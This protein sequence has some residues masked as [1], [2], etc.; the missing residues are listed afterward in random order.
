MT[1]FKNWE[2]FVT[3]KSE[4]IPGP[5]DNSPIAT[6]HP[7]T[8]H[9]IFKVGSDSASISLEMWQ[10]LHG[11]YGGGPAVSQSN[12]RTTSYSEK[13]SQQQPAN[14]QRELRTP[15]K[16]D[17][18]PITPEPTHG[19]VLKTAAEH[20]SNPKDIS[21]EPLSDGAKAIVNQQLNFSDHGDN[22]CGDMNSH[23]GMSTPSDHEH[24]EEE[25]ENNAETLSL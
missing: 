20:E 2:A 19:D 11:I 17:S 16:M 4:D 18:K 24:D 22:D 12:R 13:Y 25:E 8:G 23:D 15:E 7:R 9:T 1:W 14:V 3:R 10:F 5:I 21:G 6:I